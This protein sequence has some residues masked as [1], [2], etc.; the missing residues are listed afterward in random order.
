MAK[1]KTIPLYKRWRLISAVVLAAVV[2]AIYFFIIHRPLRQ[3]IQATTPPGTSQSTPST[4]PSN[5]TTS[6]NNQTNQ[7]A[8]NQPASD[9]LPASSPTTNQ[10]LKAPSGTFVSNHKPSLSGSSAPSQEQSVCNTTPGANCYIQF[11]KGNVTKTLPVQTVNSSGSAYWTWDVQSAGFSVGSWQ[12]TAIASAN[13]QT[14]T[15][16]DSQPLEVQP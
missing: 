15:T 5:N 8:P 12:V 9:K 16:Q 4:S 6:S 14:M 10:P 13:G 1:A 3:V 7:P 2:A 11:T